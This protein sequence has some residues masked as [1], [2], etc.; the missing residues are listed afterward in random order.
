MS[1]VKDQ[2][3]TPG[4]D[5]IYLEADDEITAII[6]KVEAAKSNVVAL[7]LPKRP[8]AMQSIVNMRLL[9][10]SA[11]NAGKNIV[12]VTSDSSVLPLAGAA[13]I[14]V[15]KNTQS[16][17]EVPDAP[18]APAAETAVKAIAVAG[19]AEA[20]DS[21]DA[22]G[23]EDL[24]AKISYD[25]SIGELA[26]AHDLD[27]P[28]T[29][30]LGD[31]EDQVEKAAAATKKLPKKPKDK[32]LKVPNFDKFR[33]WLGLGIA[34]AIALIIFI[35]LAVF[36]LPK[37]T[38]AIQTTSTP[39]SGNVDLKT[40]DKVTGYDAKSQTITGYNK[41]SDQTSTQQVTATGQKNNGDKATGSVTLSQKVCGTISPPTDVPAGTGLTSSGLT[42]ITQNTTHFSSGGTTSGT[43]ITYPATAN[44]SITAQSG[45]TKYN[46]AA[47]SSFTAQGYSG[48][49]GTNS[50]AFTGGTDNIVTVV[51]QSDVDNVKQKLISA[52][53]TNFAQTFETQL[54]NQDYYVFNSTLNQADPVV[55]ANP[56][57]GQPASNTSV[58]V[59]VTYSVLAV[60]KDDLK[61]AISAA[62]N[63]QIDKTK[64]KLDESNLINDAQISVT[65]QSSPTN[66]SLSIAENTSAVPLL[67]ANA[68]KAQVAGKK[69][70]VVN[71]T[72]SA[73][74]GVKS[75]NVK[76]SPF[77]VSKVPSKKAK[78]TVTIQHV[79]GS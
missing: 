45:G 15:A 3:A 8:A 53:S 63:G 20:L 61:A 50:S 52:S 78:I 62:L 6:D 70:G 34:G 14:H 38:I 36:V 57:V 24:P 26:E 65:N 30:E 58:T 2:P 54:A 39:V 66:A 35:I 37:A 9:A 67:D 51:S 18:A 23:E 11:D 40:S 69:A 4:K 13:G 10:R 29:I 41:T 49:T 47:G 48:V 74:P 77:W 44:T 7:V 22:D 16:K 33:L 31:D 71:D 64:Q 73:I 72:I 19:A 55:T 43:C 28:E 1:A 5:T 17:P 27:H 42:F 75:V 21:D 60:K 59:K 32:A 68:I 79:N 56:A 25:K 12:L 76:L 46:L